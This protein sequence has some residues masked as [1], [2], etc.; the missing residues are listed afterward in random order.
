MIFIN[1]PKFLLC[2]FNFVYKLLIGIFTIR[3]SLNF[4]SKF[5]LSL[6]SFAASEF[7]VIIIIIIII[8]IMTLFIL[9]SIFSL[10]LFLHM[11]EM[12]LNYLKFLQQIYFCIFCQY[13]Y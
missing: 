12:G 2:I 6:Y 8:I 13:Y 5:L 3:L 1:S 4:A 11:A 9:G 10:K 7:I